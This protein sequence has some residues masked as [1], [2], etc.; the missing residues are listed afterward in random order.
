[1]CWGGVGPKGVKRSGACKFLLFQQLRRVLLLLVITSPVADPVLQR[2][3][4]R[5]PRLTTG[6]VFYRLAATQ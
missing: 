6:R 1:M 5:E 3:D 2:A 4:F